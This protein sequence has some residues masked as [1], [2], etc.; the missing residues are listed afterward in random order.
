M[1]LGL[2]LLAGGAI[3]RG[4]WPDVLPLYI[5]TVILSAG[6][7]LAQTAV[8]VLAR[9]WFPTRIGLVAALFTDGL[10]LGET[11]SASLTLP[12]MKRFLGPDGW[13]GMLLF[14][15]RPHCLCWRSGWSSRRPPPPRSPRDP[16][17]NPYR[18]RKTCRHAAG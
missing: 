18:P 1:A 14:G 2:A 15:P 6:I 16:P 10:I 12:L 9:Q 5:F 4:V 11:F 3:L 13:A 17:P 7:T 8:P